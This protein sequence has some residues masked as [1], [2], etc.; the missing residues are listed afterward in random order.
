MSKSKHLKNKLHKN[1]FSAKKMPL[2]I[3]IEGFYFKICIFLLVYLI[4]QVKLLSSD[5]LT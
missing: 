2:D 5:S 4:S 3:I 1:E